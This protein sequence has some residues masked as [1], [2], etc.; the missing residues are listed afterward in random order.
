MTRAVCAGTSGRRQWWRLRVGGG[1]AP[2]LLARKRQQRGWKAPFPRALW[3]GGWSA[4]GSLRTD[5]GLSYC[6]VGVR[7]GLPQATW[8][9]GVSGSCV[10]RGR[11]SPPSQLTCGPRGRG[12]W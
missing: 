1:W 6:L 11:R 9:G 3:A 2:Q 7:A 4:L 12:G 5:A 8:R 10:V